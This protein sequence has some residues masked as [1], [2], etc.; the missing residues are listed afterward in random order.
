MATPNFIGC[1]LSSLPLVEAI[2]APR[3][4]KHEVKHTILTRGPPVSP[5]HDDYIRQAKG[6]Q[7]EF[8]YLVDTGIC[9]PSSSCWASP[10][11]LVPKSNGDWRPCGDYRKLNEATIPDRYP[12]SHIQDC[13]Q[14]LDKKNFLNVRFGKGLSSD[15]RAGRGHSEK[16]R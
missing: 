11:H 5:S 15:S 9:R 13:L 2:S 4:L 3:K 12:V 6:H 1:S 10:L 8:Q 16:L 7:Q 14:V